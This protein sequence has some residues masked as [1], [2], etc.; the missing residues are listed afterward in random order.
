[1]PCRV[2]EIWIEP[3]DQA[4]KKTGKQSNGQEEDA[5]FFKPRK[6]FVQ[7]PGFI[8]ALIRKREGVYIM[9]V[10]HGVRGFGRQNF[11][12]MNIEDRGHAVEL[13]MVSRSYK[14]RASRSE[15]P[16]QKTPRL[17][18]E[19]HFK[20]VPTGLHQLGFLMRENLGMNPG[21]RFPG[22]RV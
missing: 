19:T 11:L 8:V 18:G 16:V 13:A 20:A 21:Q 12:H 22:A 15:V 4:G 17:Y 6:R 9:D 14:L 2:W 10:L 5:H 3:S 1:M 7:L